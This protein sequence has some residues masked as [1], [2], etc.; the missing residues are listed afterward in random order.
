MS[1]VVKNFP[2]GNFTDDETVT[3]YRHKLRDQEGSLFKREGR[4]NYESISVVGQ[5]LD[6][7][8]V[9][10]PNFI[11]ID[12]EGAEFEILKGAKK[13]FGKSSPLVGIELTRFPDSSSTY[14]PMQF[15]EILEDMQYDI[16]NISGKLVTLE[17]WL[18]PSFFMNHQN[19]L[20]KRETLSHIFA[21]EKIPKFSKAFNWGATDNVPY[22]FKL[23]DF[24]G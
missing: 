4:E 7:I 20:A 17:K 19:W 2:L 14:T 13:L 3:F 8:S 22:P 11:K 15:L 18:D 12:V 5:K 23:I 10:N 21:L 1:V 9:K 6:S 24:P 16:F